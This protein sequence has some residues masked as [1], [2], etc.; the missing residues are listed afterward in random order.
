MDSYFFVLECDTKYTPKVVL[1]C[2][3]TG[4]TIEAKISRKIWDSTITEGTILIIPAFSQ[5]E[6]QTMDKET[7]K[8]KPNGKIVNWVLTYDILRMVI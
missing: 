8:W 2:M 3:G 4:E 6:G 1:Y 7:G 5:K